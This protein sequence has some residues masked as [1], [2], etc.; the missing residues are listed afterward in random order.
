M[1]STNLQSLFSLEGKTALVTG[2]GTGLGRIMAETMAQAGAKV[3]IC[4]R[5]LANVKQAAEEINEI[6][7]ENLAL[8]VE[9]DISNEDG[10]EKIYKDVINEVN[11]LDI[12][13]NNSGATW[14]EK[15]GNFPYSAWA[16]VLD[17]NVTGLFHL[18]QLFLNLLE[19][20]ADK[21]DPSRII[22]LGSV[23]G[24]APHGDGPY[25]YSASKAA[26]HHLTK[27]L[28]KELGPRNITV[29]AFAPGPFESKMTKFAFST[30]KKQKA[31]AE[32][33]PL[34][35]TG[36]PLDISAA[37]LYLCGRGGGYVTGAVL[38]LDGGIHVDTGPELFEPAKDG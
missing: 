18:T 6:V 25:S 22:N 37:T 14:G 7:G 4:S 36:K 2:G 29:N 34:K 24:S 3:L 10:V 23:M 21:N 13:I 27:I 9:G 12:L 1:L 35:R 11:K 5:K 15:L 28:A 8:S 38:P 30:D 32:S 16:K 31:M 17:V 19:E 33:I 20:S 26:V